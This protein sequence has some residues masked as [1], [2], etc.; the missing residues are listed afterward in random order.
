MKHA[1]RSLQTQNQISFSSGIRYYW[2]LRQLAALS[3]TRGFPSVQTFIRFLPKTNIFLGEVG[4]EIPVFKTFAVS[5]PVLA[6]LFVR[7]SLA[8]M[9]GLFCYLGAN[10]RVQLWMKLSGSFGTVPVFGL[11]FLGG[12][13]RGWRPVHWMCLMLTDGQQT[14]FY[15]SRKTRVLS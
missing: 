12:G 6:C 3:V 7:D 10:A 14:D 9:S 15:V 5:V 8:L 11:S 1:V 2:F 4:W 13:A